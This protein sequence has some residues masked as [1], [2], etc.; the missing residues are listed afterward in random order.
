MRKRMITAMLAA[1][2]CTA[3]AIGAAGPVGAEERTS[4]QAPTLADVLLS[5]GNQFDFNPFDYDI[6]TEAVLLYPD[7]VAAAADPNAE[8]TAFLPNDL[9]FR[10]LV[11]E[12]TGAW[13]WRERAVFDAVAA[14]GT[15][16]VAAVLQ[17]HIVAGAPISYEAAKQAD[18]AVLTPLQGGTIEVDVRGRWWKLVRLIDND[19]DARD[20]LVVQ[21]EIGGR[22]A[23]GYAHGIDSV[24][25]PVDL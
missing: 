21:P 17:Y 25:R 7:L 22:A 14:L 5:D 23:N 20:P 4:G 24:L 9:A 6:V 13:P 18:G 10:K 3:L 8:L 19:P 16:T 11:A 15:D 2:T 1:A 12:L